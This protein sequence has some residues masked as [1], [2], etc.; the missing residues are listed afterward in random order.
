MVNDPRTHHPTLPDILQTRNPC[1]EPRRDAL[2]ENR[3]LSEMVHNSQITSQFRGRGGEPEHV[4]AYTPDLTAE[5]LATA[6]RP[7]E[8]T[9]S[10]MQ[11]STENGPL[12]EVL[13]NSH[14]TMQSAMLNRRNHR[15]RRT[16][17]GETHKG[18]S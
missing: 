9:H 3:Q 6:P 8:V 17:Q 7:R 1:P 18:D 11:N 16:A 4:F 2:T 13:T 12:S 14:F 15:Q 10:G 5:E